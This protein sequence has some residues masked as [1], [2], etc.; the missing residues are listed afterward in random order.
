MTEEAT[1]K[2]VGRTG[3][4]AGRIDGR[5]M[6]RLSL[7][8]IFFWFGII[9]PFEVSPAVLLVSNSVEEL[10]R[11]AVFLPYDVFMPLLGWWEAAV[12]LLLLSRR[13]VP[14][15]VLFMI[16]QMLSTM[17]ALVILP[18]ITFIDVPFV[19][20]AAGMYII[21]NWVLLSAGL[22]VLASVREGD[23]S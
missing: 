17:I 2:D 5:R 16:P 10:R 11:I 8:V 22:V 4:L 7:A 13:T 21:K 6:L 12:G 23:E 18:G 15:A 19:P 1:L 9:K 20:S 3:P 14:I